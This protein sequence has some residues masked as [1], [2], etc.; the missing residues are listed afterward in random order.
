M[1]TLS[2]LVYVLNCLPPP[3]SFLSTGKGPKRN[4][5]HYVNIFTRTSLCPMLIAVTL[6]GS[7]DT[8]D[9]KLSEEKKCAVW[10]VRQFTLM[11]F[12]ISFCYKQRDLNRSQ[13][14]V[15]LKGRSKDTV[16][17]YMLF[18]CTFSVKQVTQNLLSPAAAMWA[19]FILP[20]NKSH[21]HTHT[22]T[23]THTHTKQSHYTACQL[24]KVRDMKRRITKLLLIF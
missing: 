4:D 22:R 16:R 12:S 18:T 3:T 13:G 20:V 23:H 2:L 19:H 8:L 17:T 5:T 21:T 14:K 11:A 10:I 7:F 24:L 6:K 1:C 15:C 9:C